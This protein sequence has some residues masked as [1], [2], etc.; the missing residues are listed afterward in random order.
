MHLPK[1]QQHGMAGFLCFL[2][3]T[4]AP[5]GLLMHL[6]VPATWLRLL[7]GRYSSDLL[8]GWGPSDGYDEVEVASS[9]PDHPNVWTDGSLLLDRV[10]GISSSGAGFFA[11]SSK[12]CWSGRMWGHVDSVRAGGDGSS[13]R[14]FCSALVPLQSVQRTEMWGV[15][16]ALQSS[17]AI[18]LG[19]DNLGVVRHFWSSA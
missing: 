16:L 7:S 15:I 13:S 1:Q 4:G 18:H 19:V 17:G 10:T 14:G 9:M 2:E 11:H 6:R 3:L 8:A 5:L 12:E